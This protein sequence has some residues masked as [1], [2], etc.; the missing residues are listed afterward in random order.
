MSSVVFFI[1]AKPLNL[2]HVLYFVFFRTLIFKTLLIRKPQLFFDLLDS[3]EVIFVAFL[4]LGF[5]LERDQFRLSANYLRL[6]CSVGFRHQ[7]LN[8]NILG[9]ELRA[10]FL[11][12]FYKLVIIDIHV[13]E[14]LN[15]R[16]HGLFLL[17]YCSSK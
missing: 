4:E 12:L 13:D 7:V 17:R 10:L 6:I 8:L 5:I 2:D 3:L 1:V 9:Q 16:I 14:K 15:L 11:Q